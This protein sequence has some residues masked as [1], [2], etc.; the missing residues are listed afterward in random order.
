MSTPK[1]STRSAGVKPE[2]LE[3]F[4]PLYTRNV[5][6]LAQLQKK[7]LDAAAEQNTEFIET[8]K[9]AFDFVPE[10]PGLFVFDLLGQNFDRFVETQKGAIDVAVEQSNAVAELA[11]ERSGSV[12][13][14]AEGATELFQKTAEQTLAAQKKALD[15][16]AKQYKTAYETA[17]SQFKISNPA[18]EAF[19]TGMDALIET[20]KIVLDIAWKPLK[21]LS[22]A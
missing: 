12:A 13:K 18:A 4:I 21:S 9:K 11:K 5:E 10:T 14:I 3:N 17:K 1:K 20:Q 15:A 22:A 2:A 19:Q 16:C 7:S 6:R 8:C